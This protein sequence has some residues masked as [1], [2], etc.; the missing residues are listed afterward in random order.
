MF[1]KIY[2]QMWMELPHEIRLQLAKDFELVKSKGTEV[3]DQQVVSDGHTVADLA[4]IT[5]AKMEEYVGSTAEFPRLWEITVSKARSIVNPAVDFV[6][7]V[8]EHTNQP[9]SSAEETPEETVTTP[10]PRKNAKAKKSTSK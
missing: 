8:A 9:D 7:M 6:E 3:I 5:K 4:K 2:P 10:N 1:E